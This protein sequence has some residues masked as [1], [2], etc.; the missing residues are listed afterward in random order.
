M[1]ATEKYFTLLDAI[2]RMDSCEELEGAI[3]LNELMRQAKYW[4][5][6]AKMSSKS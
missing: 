6:Q 2:D 4:E 3:N 5:R 1:D